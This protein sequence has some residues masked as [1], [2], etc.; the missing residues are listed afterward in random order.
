MYNIQLLLN[1]ILVADLQPCKT[2]TSALKV[3]EYWERQKSFRG[4]KFDTVKIE[5]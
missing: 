2:L 4:I 5:A 3:Q 1:G